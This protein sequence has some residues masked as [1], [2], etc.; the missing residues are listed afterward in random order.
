MS[1]NIE[2]KNEAYN[3]I[4]SDSDPALLESLA[5]HIVHYSSPEFRSMSKLVSPEDVDLSHERALVDR[6]E[7][8]LVDARKAFYENGERGDGRI[9]F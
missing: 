7:K 2:R 8:K 3:L 9:H 4:R 6:D 5:E 1:I